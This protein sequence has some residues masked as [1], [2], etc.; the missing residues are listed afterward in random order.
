MKNLRII[1]G[2]RYPVKS[3]RPEIFS[4]GS[5]FAI[6]PHGPEGDRE[7]MVVDAETH[8]HR[9]QRRKM[10][11]GYHPLALVQP[12]LTSDA[13][14]LNA[15]HMSEIRIPLSSEGRDE[16]MVN[17]WEDQVRALLYNE[18]SHWFSDYLQQNCRLVRRNALRLINRSY[19]SAHAAVSFA[20]RNQI[21]AL[22]LATIAQFNALLLPYSLSASADNFRPNLLFDGCRDREEN[23][24]QSIRIGE[25]ELRSTVPCQRCEMPGNNPQT[26]QFHKEILHVL[27]KH[28]KPHT[29]KPPIFGEQFEVVKSGTV[30]IGDSVTIREQR[31]GGWEREF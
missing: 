24:F 26:A 18:G 8:E 11:R 19:A 10:H 3:C 5:A 12:T 1:E 9:T 2:R 21:H 16:N 29:D 22:S 31:S 25:V 4:E 23:D 27:G 28:Y 17:I 30:R 7:F 15:P 20:D 14:I 6:G 13:L